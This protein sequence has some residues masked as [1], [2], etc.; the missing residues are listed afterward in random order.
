MNHR[1]DRIDEA[2][3]LLAEAVQSAEEDIDIAIEAWETLQTT[4]GE[5]YTAA[6]NPQSFTSWGLTSIDASLINRVGE[7]IHGAQFNSLATEKKAA[8]RNI[9]RAFKTEIWMIYFV[10]GESLI[11]N[12]LKSLKLILRIKRLSSSL[13]LERLLT[14]LE[15]ERFKRRGV[16][17]RNESNDMT[18]FTFYDVKNS[19]PALCPMLLSPPASVDGSVPQNPT[20]P[21]IYPSFCRASEPVFKSKD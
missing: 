11:A 15:E 10:L 17:L 20:T 1:L 6:N 3:R 19:V 9:A 18:K 13:T 21:G 14:S 2:L 8:L 12:T 4:Y 7:W 16:R 5:E